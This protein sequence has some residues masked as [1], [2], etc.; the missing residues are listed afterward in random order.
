MANQQ[1]AV[2]ELSEELKALVDEYSEWWN[3]HSNV[4][5]KSEDIPQTLYHYTDMSGLLGILNSQVIWNTN[6]YHLNDP[7]EWQ[8]GLKMAREAIDKEFA[9]DDPLTRSLCSFAIEATDFIPKTFYSCFVSSFSEVGDDLG[10]WRAYADDGRGV[11]I[12]LASKLFEIGGPIPE[13]PAEK[14]LVAKVAYD[15]GACRAT[16]T[17]S[18]AVARDVIFRGET[19]PRS[20]AEAAEFRKQIAFQFVLSVFVFATTC[21][22]DAYVKEAEVRQILLAETSE[23]ANHV[24]LRVRGPNLVPYVPSPLKVR[25]EDAIKRIVVGPGADALAEDAVKSLLRKHG[26]PPEI[27]EPSSIPYVSQRSR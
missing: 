8:H 25:D 3:S 10:Q 14:T 21:K 15:P 23:I 5:E 16:L 17:E 6:V 27:V 13:H 4:I 7:S 26:L 11:A 1:G 24:Q 22:H 18:L 19:L 12:G 2:A 9:K 20:K